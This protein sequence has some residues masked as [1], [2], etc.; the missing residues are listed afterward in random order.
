VKIDY[1]DATGDGHIIWHLGHGGDFALRGAAPT[2]VFPWFSHQHGIEN[3]GSNDPI[4][5]FDNGNTRCLG[6][7]PGTCVSRGQVYTLDEPNLVATRTV[8]ASMGNLSVALG[9]SQTLSNGDYSFTSGFQSATG[10]GEVEEFNRTGT[11]ITYAIVDPGTSLYRGYRMPN[12]YS[13]CCGD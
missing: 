9:W 2:E 13:G 8:N 1:A 6:A 11:T 3:L 5:T 4:V 12:M 10:N 7:A